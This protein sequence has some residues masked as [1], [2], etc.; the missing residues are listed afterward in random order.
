MAT[1][2]VTKVC[3]YCGKEFSAKRDEAKF[4]SASCRTKAYRKRHGIPFP[5][6]SKLVTTKMPTEKESKL[7]M[8]NDEL[9][10]TNIEERTLEKQYKIVL[11]KYEQALNNYEHSPDNWSRENS[12]RKK[13]ELDEVK[14]I[15]S[16]KQLKRLALEK[17]I[18]ELQVGIDR[19]FLENRQLIMSA[20][21]IIQMKFDIL[22]LDGK[23]KELLGKPSSNFFLIIYGPAKSGKT[24]FALQFANY[25]KMFGS[26]VYIAVYE[27]IS[28]SIQQKLIDNQITGID[29]SRAKNKMEIDFVI[30]KGKYDFVFIDSAAHASL[31]VGD[32]E[33]MKIK[34]PRT[35]FIT[36]FQVSE[37][38]N[39]QLS[40]KFKQRC[41]ILVHINDGIATSV[42]RLNPKRQFRIFSSNGS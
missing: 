17:Q 4:C 3:D 36:V 6:F 28:L 24:S 5:D 42:G 9:N 1:P 30:K 15:L 18:T 32:I 21:D 22:D 8:L 16:D 11:E 25:I 27:K 13:K 20:D 34:F 23:W 39:I 7:M 37:A 33:E 10:T 2:K 26:V 31:N 12:L 38:D 41:D 14:N 29:L 35:S 19:E 40:D